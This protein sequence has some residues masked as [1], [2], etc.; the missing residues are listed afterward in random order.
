MFSGTDLGVFEKYRKAGAHAFSKKVVSDDD[1]DIYWNIHSSLCHA[2][3]NAITT[4]KFDRWFEEGSA[5]F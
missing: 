4:Q 5:R 1:K 3:G 2:A